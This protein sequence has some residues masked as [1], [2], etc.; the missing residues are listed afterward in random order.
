MFV[1]GAWIDASGDALR[2]RHPATGECVFEAPGADEATVDAA[3]SAA[4]R[5]FDE[6]P[7]PRLTG[8]D[9][10]R[11]MRKIAD[12]IRADTANLN[13]LLSL[14]NATPVSFVGF[15]QMGAEYPADLFE[16]YA[17]WIDKV[18]GE[19]FPQWEPTQP[20]TFTTHEPIGVVGLITPW[21]APLSLLAQKVAPALGA[22]CTVVSKP[23]EL[24]PLTSLRIGELI[25]EAD[26]P[27]GVFNMIAGPGDPV[28]TALVGDPRVDKVSFT[29][30]KAV[31][32][33]IASIV[34]ARIGSVSLELGGKSPALI[35]ADADISMAVAMAAGN[36]FLGMSGQVCV[37]QSR[38]LVERSAYD[39][40]LDN[41]IGFAGAASYGDPFDPAVTAA[42]MISEQHME[43]V[44]GHISR[45]V[46]DG[47]QIATGGARP[48][49]APAAGNFVA[50]TLLVDVDNSMA[51]AREEIFGPVLCLIPFDTEDEAI[52]IANDTSY[53]LGAAVYTKDVSRAVRVS[54]ALRAGNV[55]VNTWTLQPHAPFGGIKQSGL[56]SENGRAGIMEYLDTKTTF[57][58]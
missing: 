25:A 54:A 46:D 32:S 18:T 11:L 22:G 49:S 44:L 40:V 5:A 50:P 14:D 36:A 21:N 45:A 42:P 13:A 1:D 16:T 34:G 29:G 9:R 4:R 51:A 20:L 15:Y 47:A 7:W 55:G 17:G 26:L 39:E 8:R 53:G 56:G 10:A 58:A 2:H 35:F 33:A 41:L 52:R 38:I 12:L 57:I 48:D 23:S 27:P 37:C 6:G 24:A 28:G 19:T 31:G 43:L 30:S 3:V